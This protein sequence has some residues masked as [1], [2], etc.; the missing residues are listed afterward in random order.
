MLTEGQINRLR[1]KLDGNFFNG[2]WHGFL[3]PDEIL[4]LKKTGHKVQS[5]DIDWAYTAEKESCGHLTYFVRN[6]RSV[7]QW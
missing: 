1:D 5:F 3:C 4:F 2:Y 7:F 6:E